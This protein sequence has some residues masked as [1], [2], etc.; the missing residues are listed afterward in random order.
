M[1]FEIGDK[2]LLLHSGE[3]G[4]IV[5]QINEEMVMVEVG[6]IQFPVYADQLDYPYFKSFS[7]DKRV[8]K[9]TGQRG[10]DIPAERK[11]GKQG[12]ETGVWLSFLPVYMEESGEEAV[13]ELKIFLINETAHSYKL[14][15]HLYTGQALFLE[16]KNEIPP[17][18]HFYLNNLL[19]EALNDNPRFEFLFSL[20]EPD[21]KSAETFTKIFKPK[22]KQVFRKL[23]ELGERQDA[24]F[25]FLLF[26]KYPDRSIPE[27]SDFSMGTIGSPAKISNPPRDLPGI[28]EPKY[29]IDLHIERLMDNWRGL[30]NFEI[31]TIQL[32]EFQRYLDLAI[33]HK[34]FSM[35]VIH[36]V[37]KGK[38]RD[39]IHQVLQHTPEVRNFVNQ[40]DVR[41]G[42][43]A[44]EI[45]FTPGH[46]Y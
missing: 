1:K 21:K 40:Y 43:G 46:E 23:G 2:I 27:T 17:F 45:F 34:Q 37:G 12:E 22:P 13:H 3:T 7:E 44:T 33:A 14:H 41:Y 32:H 25:R 6:G 18:S 31:L 24:S 9:K 39:E 20:K 5:E 16:V 42:Y 36:G 19:F 38:L 30:S 4:T 8:F 28:Y 26:E 35:V 11:T 29:E 15:Y 10:E